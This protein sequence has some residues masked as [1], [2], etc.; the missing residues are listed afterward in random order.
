MDRRSDSADDPHPHLTPGQGN[1]S[2]D[3]QHEAY[4]ATKPPR[5]LVCPLCAKTITVDR[6]PELI[7]NEEARQRVAMEVV[8]LG[9]ALF[10]AVLTVAARAETTSDRAL[11]GFSVEDV[12]TAGNEVF[13]TLRLL[14]D[15]D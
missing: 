6:L 8:E 10:Q 13:N 5:E 14:L 7:A 9:R 11:A 3:G 1:P 2:D 4:A 15:A 12:Q